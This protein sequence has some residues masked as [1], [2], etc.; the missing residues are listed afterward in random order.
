MREGRSA[1]SVI[2]RQRND[3]L[4]RQRNDPGRPIANCPGT[5][6]GRGDCPVRCDVDAIEYARLIPRLEHSLARQVR[7]IDHSA[8][9]VRVKKPDSMSATR[10]YLPS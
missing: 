5:T 8:D 6:R 3:G 9:S 1:L 10:L 2:V 4:V 7:Q